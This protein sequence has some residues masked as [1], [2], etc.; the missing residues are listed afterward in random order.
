MTSSDLVARGDLPLL[1]V[2]SGL[3]GTGKT[4]LARA[5]VQELDAVYLRVDVVETPLV[6]AGI[7]AGPLGYQIVRELAASNL[8]LGRRVV[9]DL[10]NPLPVTRRMWTDLAAEQA[11]Q[12]IVFE[13]QLPDAAEHRRRV[14]ARTPDLSDQ[15]LPTW[16]DVVSREYERWD[17]V[18]DGRRIVVDMTKSPDAIRRVM[19]ALTD[20]TVSR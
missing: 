2:V 18:R 12:L 7:E 19:V 11:V 6:R 4:T 13:C 8:V 14:E 15:V 20:G 17:E 10:V 16:T 3:P 9:V 5:L 1:L